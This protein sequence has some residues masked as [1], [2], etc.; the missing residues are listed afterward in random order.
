[1]SGAE[2]PMAGPDLHHA[3]EAFATWLRVERNLSPRTREAYAW[4][5]GQ[6]TGWFATKLGKER[7]PLRTVSED[8]VKNYVEF[9]RSERAYKAATLNRTVSC[10]RTFFRFCIEERLLEANPASDLAR[11][12]KPRKL[13]V[14]LVPDELRRL[15]DAPDVSTS[16]GRRDR[17]ILVTL[18]Y[19]GLRLQ[20]LVGL[21]TLDLDFSRDTVR[22]FG[23]GSKERL[24]PLNPEV[25]DALRAT[26]DDPERKPA[27]GERAVF[28][29][30]AGRRMSGRAVQYI[31][32]RCVIQAGISRDA[33]S[34]HKLRHTFATL[35]HTNDVELVDIQALM[36]HASLSSTQIYTHTNVGR[37]RGAIDRLELKG[38]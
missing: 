20:E 36:G 31:V 32:D 8:H 29:N 9:L 3:I 27:D 26:L 22:V 19:C 18:A 10:L 11:P 37:L 4:D 14:F 34:P 2:S 28:L 13:P 1:M 15:F 25:R 33:L 17:A 24:V 5:L 23:K 35:L 6:F 38:A 16:A 7:V 12:K 21:D 30:R